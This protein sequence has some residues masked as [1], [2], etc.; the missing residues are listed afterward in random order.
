MSSHGVMSVQVSS[1]MS[2]YNRSSTASD[3]MEQTQL[4]KTNPNT[5]VNTVTQPLEI[6]S[7]SNVH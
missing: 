7:A 2:S 3:R 4:T 5:Y 1:K 6:I